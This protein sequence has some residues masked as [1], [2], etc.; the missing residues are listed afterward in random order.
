M[1]SLLLYILTESYCSQDT[2]MFFELLFVYSY[3]F[4]V[5]RLR[6]EM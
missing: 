3:K 4:A 5:G 2:I 6:L 1:K